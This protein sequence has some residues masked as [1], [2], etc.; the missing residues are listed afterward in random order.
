[1]DNFENVSYGN[2]ENNYFGAETMEELDA[3]LKTYGRSELRGLASKLGL[4]PTHSRALMREVIK[5]SFRE[6]KSRNSPIPA[7]TPMF[8]EA[9]EEIK[10]MIQSVSKISQDEKE[11]KKWGKK[12]KK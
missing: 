5:K 4:N 3:K 10:D 6:Y 9:S 8:S 1:M 2:G 12:R 7:P 11:K